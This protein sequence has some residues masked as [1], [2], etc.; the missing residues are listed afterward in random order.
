MS[1]THTT[2]HSFKEADETDSKLNSDQLLSEN[3]TNLEEKNVP[4]FPVTDIV[5]A[6]SELSH[7]EEKDPIPKALLAAL[8]TKYSLHFKKILST[9]HTAQSIFVKFPGPIKNKNEVLFQQPIISFNRIAKIYTIASMPVTYNDP[10]ESSDEHS[11]FSFRI[12]VHF[13]KL[14]TALSRFITT[15]NKIYFC[16]D[17][18]DY[19]WSSEWIEAQEMCCKCIMEG[20]LYFSLS[21]SHLCTICQQQ[22]KRMYKTRCAHYFHR[23]CLFDYLHSNSDLPRKCPNCRS[24]LIEDEESLVVEE[25]EEL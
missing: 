21:K 17:C 19:V 10:L 15:I 4:S 25:E 18:G 11:A 6:S 2:N 5:I 9:N 1:V 23:K 13:K 20:C 8:E 7:M 24:I 14:K 3:K 12:C 16:K 22:G